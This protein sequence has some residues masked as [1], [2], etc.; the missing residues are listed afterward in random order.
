MKVFFE[1]ETDDIPEYDAEKLTGIIAD[2]V[3][4]TENCPFQAEVNILIT[5]AAGIQ[6]A[7]RDFRDID[8][9]T[10]VL[11]FPGIEYEKPADFDRIKKGEADCFDPETG[12]LMLG[13][14]MINIERVHSQAKEYGHSERREFAFLVAHSMLHLCGYD[15]M[16]PGDAK[17]MEAKQEAVLQ[18]L[19]ITRENG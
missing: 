6:T 5:D 18:R 10:D 14:I 12:D 11:S 8:K 15:H 2:E 9:V 16:D 1:N 7:N 3:L 13:D 4:K 17:I 19:G